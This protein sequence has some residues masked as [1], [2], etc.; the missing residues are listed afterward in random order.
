MKKHLLLLLTILLPIFAIA[1]P[2]GENIDYFLP[3]GEF[4][5]NPEITTPKEYFGFNLGDQHVTTS[6][7]Y[8]YFDLLAKE[9]NRFS[10]ERHGQTY[11]YRPLVYATVTSADNMKNIDKIREEHLKLSDPSIASS[12][13]IKNMPIVTWLGYS[14]HGNEQSGMNSSI[15]VAYFLVAAQGA[16]IDNI[17]N[18][19][20]IIIHPS[21]NPDGSDRFAMWVNSNRSFTTVSDPVSREFNEPWPG[22]RSNHY[23]FDLNRD[24]LAVVHPE[25]KSKIDMFLKWRPNIVNDHHEQGSNSNFFFMP[26]VETRT[27]PITHKDNWKLTAKVGEFHAKELDKIGSFYFTKEGFDDFYYGKGSTYPDIHGAVGMLFEQGSSRGHVRE[28]VNGIMPFAF[29]IRNQ[30]Y[31]SYSTIRASIALKNELLQ[32]QIDS[33]VDGYN[34]AKTLPF[35]GYVFGDSGTKSISTHFLEILKKH[36]I[37]VY[38]L[39][40]DIVADGI[41]YSKGNSYVVPVSQREARTIE[42]LFENVTKFIDS[43]FYDISGWTFIEAMNLPNFRMKSIQG[44]LGDKI[45]D[46]QKHEGQVIGGKS[47]LAYLFNIN[48]YYAPKFIYELQKSGLTIRV[49]KTPFDFKIDGNSIKFNYGAIM[50]R[51]NNQCIDEDK[52]FALMSSLAKSTAVDVYSVKTGAS[53]SIALGSSSFSI[54]PMP[55]VA[56]LIGSGASSLNVGEVWHLFD[57]RFQM[58]LTLLD[59]N[60]VSASALA[61]YNRLVVTGAHSQLSPFAKSALISWVENGGVLITMGSGW[62]L[63]N[64]L[65]ITSLVAK[66]REPV[67]KTTSPQPYSEMATANSGNGIDGVLLKATIDTSHPIAWGYNQKTISLYHSG[68]T[69]FENI[70]NIYNTPLSYTD[71]PL[72]SGF[73]SAQNLKHLAETPA[74]M[75]GSYGRGKIVI[76]ND[77][78]IFRGFWYGTNKLFMNS[79]F[80][81]PLISTSKLTSL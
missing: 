41:K 47:S 62:S 22:S 54:I 44:Y 38:H 33:Y 8:G 29:T 71:K 65:G 46:I 17:L 56:V 45:E 31:T 67:Q 73:V 80:F 53:E 34:E 23:W 13:N 9:S 32:H 81:S 25:S 39:N 6:Q 7:L 58:P 12:M 11:E 43:S 19:S 48:E 18:N 79:I 28:T 50:V 74:V 36:E 49:A 66:R 61:P 3:K 64:S 37:D 40:K 15:A 52:I 24:L 1:Q 57:Q 51:A 5:Y 70:Q 2:S 77:N 78:P 60:S 68:T 69:F 16:E 42:T 14:I 35:Q 59:N 4:T 30:A 10:V 26:G 75:V 76:F 27:N 21:I 63:A 55:K 20:V 72:V